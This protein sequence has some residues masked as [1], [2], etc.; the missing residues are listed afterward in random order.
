MSLQVFK[1]TTVETF[2][3][4]PVFS[5]LQ[6]GFTTEK[7][8]AACQTFYSEVKAY[9]SP[10]LSLSLNLFFTLE[11][12]SPSLYHVKLKFTPQSSSYNSLANLPICP[13]PGWSPDGLLIWAACPVILSF[14]SSLP[15]SFP[16]SSLSSMDHSPALDSFH[17]SSSSKLLKES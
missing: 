6:A 1:C 7:Q 11:F 17:S 12:L 16:P 15:F 13:Q 10:L 4:T 14:P 9:T 2:R 3:Q 8:S 5:D